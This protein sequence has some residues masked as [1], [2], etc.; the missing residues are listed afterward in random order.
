MQAKE[1]V[2]VYQ[3][4]NP[5][6]R[7]SSKG[8]KV[9]PVYQWNSFEKIDAIKEGVSKEELENLKNGAELDYDT[10]AKLLNVTKATLHSKKGKAKFDQYISERIF[11]I[12]D[13]YSYGYEVF[14]NRQK[15]NSWMKH[16]NRALGGIT[17][18]SLIDTLYGIEEVRHLIG[19]IEYGVYS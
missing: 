3:T 4:L 19:R 9:I 15:F 2:V 18:L 5:L 16:E 11:L 10:L 6:T 17:P 1:A 8:A 12:A 13:L 7:V 14:G